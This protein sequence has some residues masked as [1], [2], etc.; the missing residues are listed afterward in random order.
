MQ[1]KDAQMYSKVEAQQTLDLQDQVRVLALVLFYYLKDQSMNT[2]ILTE[3]VTILDFIIRVITCAP[4]LGVMIGFVIYEI[5]IKP[6]KTHNIQEE[7]MAKGYP[8][9]DSYKKYIWF[10]LLKGAKLRIELTNHVVEASAEYEVKQ[11]ISEMYHGKEY[12]KLDFGNGK[13]SKEY[14]T[15]NYTYREVL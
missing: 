3:D 15:P 8:K 9:P 7:L 1:C 2:V 5:I 6:I 12:F 13:Y 4:I 11:V 10:Q 14:S